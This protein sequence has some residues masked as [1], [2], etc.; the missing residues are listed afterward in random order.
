M[1]DIDRLMDSRQIQGQFGK[2]GIE[3]NTYKCIWLHVNMYEYN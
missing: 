1:I 3:E 2:E